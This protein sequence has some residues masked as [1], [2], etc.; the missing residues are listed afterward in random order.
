MLLA[1]VAMYYTVGST[2]FEVLTTADLSFDTQ[3]IM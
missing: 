1:F 2:D 3:K